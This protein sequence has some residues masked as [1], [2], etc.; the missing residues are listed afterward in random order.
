ML[1][2]INSEETRDWDKLFKTKRY[3]IISIFLKASQNMGIFKHFF[4][5]L[6]YNSNYFQIIFL[7]PSLELEENVN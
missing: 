4:L 1:S 5:Y 7:S 6:K 2:E 3:K